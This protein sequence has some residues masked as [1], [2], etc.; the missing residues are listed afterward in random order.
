MWGLP[1]AGRRDVAAQPVL[2]TGAAGFVGQSLLPTLEG[3]DYQV[4]G[5]SRHGSSN[6]RPAAPDLGPEAD[7]RPLLDGV[8][9]IVHLAGRAHVMRD[10]APD[11]LAEYRRVNVDG[12]RRL[13]EQAAAAG[14]RRLV[15]V[16]SI[17]VS[18]EDTTGRAPYRADQSPAPEDFYGISKWEAEQA[19]ADVAARTGLEVV[20]VRPPLVYGPGVKGNFRRLVDLVRRGTPL[21]LGAVDNR[22][23]LVSVFNL[24]DLLVRCID[25]PAAAGQT[26]L[27]SDGEDLSTPE[28]IRRLAGAMDRP[29]RLV[30]V[31]PGLMRA[32][33]RLLGREGIYRRLCGSLQVDIGP[34]CE[35]LGWTPPVGVNEGLARTV[36]G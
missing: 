11:P 23:S 36:Q 18:G 17:K 30:P 25:H 1:T 4:I 16:S 33:A 31:P 7:W 5:A 9:A 20:V 29:A 24:C 27:V 21:P 8:S 32:G 14:V 34:T 6:S 15:F 26:F 35:R 13:A 22:R 10:E 28:L 3:A 12:T 2:V 19:L